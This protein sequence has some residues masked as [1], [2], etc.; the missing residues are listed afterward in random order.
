MA[1]LIFI[2]SLVLLVAGAA[3][4]YA[5]LDL[6]PTSNGVLYALSG[7]VAVSAAVVTFAIAVAIRRID[8]L[9]KLLR[10]SVSLAVSPA[11]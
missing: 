11:T 2:L 1:I 6:L 7:A 8:G 10:Q 5:S 3:G 9:A 4:G